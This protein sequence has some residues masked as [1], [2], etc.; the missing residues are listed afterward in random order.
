MD[1]SEVKQNTVQAPEQSGT[2]FLPVITGIFVGVLILSNI[3][4]SKMIQL[5][6][7]VFD[8]G[9]LIFPL[10]YIFGDV[11]TEVYGYRASRK[12]IWTG[13]FM[14]ILMAFNIWLIG[15][16][17]A[18]PGWT[19]QNDYRNILMQMPRIVLASITGYFVGEFSNSVVLSK[20]KV[21]LGGKHLWMRTIGSTLV[22]EFLDSFL[23]VA[24][25]FLG[26]YPVK[27]LAVMAFSNY[28]FKTA[29]EVLFTPFTYLI[30]GFVK[31]KEKTDVYDYNVKYTP[32]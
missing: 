30:V 1:S 23:F 26:M 15:L 25:A 10:S 31:R 27:I 7:F 3:L 12:V 32:I 8:G 14:L 11:L 18:E 29:I 16:L 24:I 4:A 5:G 28:I 6:P 21:M 19:L 17:P 2:R 20:M 13:F 9:T 22:G